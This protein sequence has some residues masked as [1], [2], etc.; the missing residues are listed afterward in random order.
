MQREDFARP[1]MLHCCK[2][3]TITYRQ[4]HEKVFNGV[5]LPVFSVNTVEEA[6][7]LQVRHCRRQYGPHP[8]MPG[9]VW[10]VFT[11][12]GGELEDLEKVSNAFRETY[13]LMTRQK[14]ATK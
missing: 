5:A 13:E 7:M 4:K 11:D 9:K 1:I 8:Q 10:Y 2:D 6:I 12:F 3:G 14:A